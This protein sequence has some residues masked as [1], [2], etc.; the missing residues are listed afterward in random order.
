MQKFKMCIVRSPSGV[1][2]EVKRGNPLHGGSGVSVTKHS[3][4]CI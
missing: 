2:V 4:V 1:S 3:G